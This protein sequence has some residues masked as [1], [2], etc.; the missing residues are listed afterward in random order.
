MSRSKGYCAHKKRACRF[1]ALVQD[2]EIIENWK[3]IRDYLKHR[4]KMTHIS[5]RMLKYWH[6]VKPFP[7]QDLPGQKKILAGRLD[8][9]IM[10]DCAKES[11]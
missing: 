4:W 6:A 2:S 9:Y 1:K 5:T 3:G 11:R 8:D 7:F 10:S